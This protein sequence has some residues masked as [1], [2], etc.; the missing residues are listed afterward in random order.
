MPLFE[1]KAQALK[2]VERTNFS[3]E[4]ELQSLTEKNLEVVFN[5]RFV[6][7]EF[8]T[9]QTVNARVKVWRVPV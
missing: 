2:A 3:L 5:C 1:I 8:S 9:G 4:K 6:A 7:S